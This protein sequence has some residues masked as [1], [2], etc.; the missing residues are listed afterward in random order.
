[1]ANL[2][3]TA[4]EVFKL[5]PEGV[6]CQV[7]ENVIYMSPAPSFQHQEIILTIGSLMHIYIKEKKLGK[8]V[9]SPVDVFLDKNNAFQ[10][11]I[12]FLSTDNLSL[13]GKDGKVHGAP[14]LV[15][16]VLSPG[17]A[18]TDK[19]KKKN[20]Y[21]ASGVKEY[22]IVDPSTKEVTSFYLAEKKFMKTPSVKGKIVSRL[23]KKT[24]KF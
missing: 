1:M 11:D 12:I 10:P 7:I 20:V 6:Y 23:L 22:F 16:E 14:D 13:I 8:C 5:L 24:F 15:I 21:E 3:R 18:N 9:A 2:P 4:V 19:V 17:N